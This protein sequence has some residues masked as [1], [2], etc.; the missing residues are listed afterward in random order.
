MLKSSGSKAVVFKQLRI[1]ISKMF[2]S[3]QGPLFKNHC[4]S[5]SLHGLHSM[6]DPLPL[7]GS[8]S[9]GAIH[10]SSQQ[11]SKVISPFSLWLL[12]YGKPWLQAHSSPPLYAHTS[13]F[14]TLSPLPSPELTSSSP[15]TLWPFFTTHPFE[16]FLATSS[17]HLPDTWIWTTWS[18]VSF[19]ILSPCP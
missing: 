8:I 10:M 18:L 11:W 2:P 9:W 5:A 3:G 17:L 4:S 7:Q 1:C 14:L 19:H 12:S 6:C 13:S 15:S 16:M